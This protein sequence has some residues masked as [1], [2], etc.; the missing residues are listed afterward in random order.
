M[1]DYWYLM[2]TLST[3][4]EC[5]RSGPFSTYNEAQEDGF[6]HHDSDYLYVGSMSLETAKEK[7]DYPP[8]K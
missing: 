6:N 8:N 3:G 4:N 7:Y 1:K 2:L 5:I